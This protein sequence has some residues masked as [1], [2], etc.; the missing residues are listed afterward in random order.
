MIVIIAGMQRSGSTFTFNVVRELLSAREST[1]IR[2]TDSLTEALLKSEGKVNLITKTHS[3]D[4]LTNQLLQ[5]GSLKCICTLRKPED[6]IASWINTFG[7]SF[8]DAITT[9]KKWFIWHHTASKYTLNIEFDEVNKYPLVAIWKISN[10]LLKTC[11]IIELVRIWW[12]FRKKAVY[13]MT[14]ELTNDPVTTT[15]IGLS[16]YDKNT[17]FHRRHIS[18]LETRPATTYLNQ[19]QIRYIRSELCNFVDENGNIL[20]QYFSK[21]RKINRSHTYTYTFDMPL[22]GDGWWDREGVR[23]M[24]EYMWRWTSKTKADIDLPLK[25]DVELELRFRI[26]AKLT[27]IIHVYVDGDTV[28]EFTQVDTYNTTGERQMVYSAYLPIWKDWRNKLSTI[29]FETDGLLRPPDSDPNN[30]DQRTL[31]IAVDWIQVV[32]KSQ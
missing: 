6:A 24:T 12:K 31:G 17:F 8:D 32:P 22:Y 1:A 10:Y 20:N 16:N 25:R 7:F 9:Y 3:P 2:T 28:V 27:D 21:I 15:D 5:K 23:N 30:K 26:R 18:S 29:T 11:N 19:D 4:D 14:K 13:S